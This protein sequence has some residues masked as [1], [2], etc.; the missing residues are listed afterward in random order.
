MK[1]FSDG[2]ADKMGD[3]SCNAYRSR[4]PAQ[5]HL[6]PV[7]RSAPKPNFQLHGSKAESNVHSAAV[8][9]GGGGLVTEARLSQLFD[10]I[11]RL[12]DEPSHTTANYQSLFSTNYNNSASGS[13]DR[14]SGGQY[15]TRY[16]SEYAN[17]TAYP[18]I[19]EPVS[20]EEG[21]R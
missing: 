1:Q 15:L 9:L 2:L 11:A 19:V 14:R 17:L 5:P 7:S 21:N 10:P 6:S 13:S 3:R 12:V 20:G 4:P 8:T 16:S 18:A